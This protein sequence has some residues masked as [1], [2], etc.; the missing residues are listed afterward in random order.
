MNG[1]VKMITYSGTDFCGLCILQK[2]HK[3]VTVVFLGRAC[4]T[5]AC[6][7]WVEAAEERFGSLTRL[8]NSDLACKEGGRKRCEM[9]TNP[10][11]CWQDL[12]PVCDVEE[13]ILV[14]RLNQYIL[15]FTFFLARDGCSGTHIPSLAVFLSCSN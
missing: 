7:D 9:R 12:Q 5:V 8:R 14:K 6:P 15:L 10:K 3:G 11:V 1:I 4:T 2:G 13:Q